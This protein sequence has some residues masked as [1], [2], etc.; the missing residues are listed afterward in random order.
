MTHPSFAHEEG[1]E[2]RDNQRLEFLGDAV[3]QV[4]ISEKLFQALPEAPEGAMTKIRASLVCEPT[5]AQIARNLNLGAY[6]RLGQ[7]EA[8]SGGG[9]NPSNLADALEALLGALYLEEGIG[10]ARRVIDL[11]FSPFWDRALAGKLEHDYKSRLYEWAQ[12]AEGREVAFEVLEALGP[13]HDRDYRVGLLVNGRL[14][15]SGRGKTKKAAEQEASFHFFQE[16]GD[17]A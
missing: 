7:G 16:E 13:E 4:L 14:V 15:A 8:A 1:G 10:A 5:L 6:L 17:L 2:V 12:A 11:L 9:D 3:L